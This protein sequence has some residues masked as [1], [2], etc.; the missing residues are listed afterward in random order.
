MGVEEDM[1]SLRLPVWWRGSGGQGSPGAKM[2]FEG[3]RSQKGFQWDGEGKGIWAE[4]WHLLQSTPSNQEQGVWAGGKEEG[5][6][7]PG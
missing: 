3:V 5:P 4:F 2:Q 1:N 7:V 6:E